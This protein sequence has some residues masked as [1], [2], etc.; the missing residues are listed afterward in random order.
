MGKNV[1]KPR[2]TMGKTWKNLE[3]TTYKWRIWRDNRGEELYKFEWEDSSTYIL[4]IHMLDHSW[5]RLGISPKKWINQS[6]IGFGFGWFLP[7]SKWIFG[8]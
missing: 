8:G 6:M 5:D 1:G 3:I 4:G 2:K 7:V